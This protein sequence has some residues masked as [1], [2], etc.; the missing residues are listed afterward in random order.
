[1]ITLY[2]WDLPQKLQDEGGWSNPS[3]AERYAD[4]ASAMFDAYGDRVTKWITFNE[5]WVFHWVGSVL[6]IHPPGHHDMASAF[7]GGHHTLRAHALAVRRFRE[8]VGKSP[9]AYLQQVRLQRAAELLGRGRATVT[10]AAF[11]A[12]FTDLGRFGR[13]FRETY[14]CTP[15][16]FAAAR[17]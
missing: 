9:Y 7:L 8:Q 6:G 16:A 17:A 5:P 1:M 11:A 13:K 12:G 14:G 10:E 4:Y 3:I 15:S 2:H